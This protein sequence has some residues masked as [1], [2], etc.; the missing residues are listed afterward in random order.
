M[1]DR[2]RGY[3]VKSSGPGEAKR[4]PPAYRT[5]DDGAEKVAEGLESG[6]GLGGKALE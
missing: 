6:G 4:N 5:L 1:R 2:V 3:E